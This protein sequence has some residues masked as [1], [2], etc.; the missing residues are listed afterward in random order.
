LFGSN[1]CI[2]R[3]LSI[4]VTF[5]EVRSKSSFLPIPLSIADGISTPVGGCNW[6]GNLFDFFPLL[7]SPFSKRHID[8]TKPWIYHMPNTSPSLEVR[9]LF[10]CDFIELLSFRFVLILPRGEVLDYNL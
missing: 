2:S 4:R 3:G 1:L 5:G 8:R 10:L 9:V 7:F 6:F